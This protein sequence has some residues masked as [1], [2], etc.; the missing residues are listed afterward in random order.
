MNTVTLTREEI[1]AM[2]IYAAEYS[3]Q[4]LGIREWWALQR[5]GRKNDV[6]EFLRELDEASR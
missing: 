6:R 4:S 5:E 2:W 1:A 3:Q